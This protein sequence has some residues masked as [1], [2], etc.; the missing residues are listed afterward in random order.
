MA[1]GKLWRLLKCIYGLIDGPRMWYVELKDTLLELGMTLSAF[2]GS[3]FFCI[4]RKSV[5]GLIALHVDDLMFGGSE[6]FLTKVI[7]SLKRKFRLST[8]VEASFVYTGLDVNQTPKGIS[9]SQFGYIHQMSEIII[10]A[11]RAKENDAPIT[12]VERKQ[13]RSVGGQLLWVATQS[14][15]DISYG[16]CVTTNSYSS[17]TVKDLKMANKTVKY[18]KNNPLCVKFPR[19][20][21]SEA[22]LLIFCD[23]SFANLP[24]GS[25]QGGHVVFVA[26]KS[27]WCCPLTWQSRKIKKVCKSTLA[28]ESWALL[29]GLESAE[30]IAIQLKEILQRSLPLMSCT[31]CKSLHD[32]IRTTNT[33]EDKG[34]RIPMACIR[35]KYN[36]KEAEFVWVPTHLQLADCL[37]K[38]GASSALLRDVLVNG[39]LPSPLMSVVF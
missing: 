2:D 21:L 15:P 26:D 30:L 39:R 36:R 10:D 11:E 19:V 9:V 18:M 7:G 8:E 32:A 22:K 4:Q 14:R 12:E 33:V 1:Q 35:Q 25:S 3:F 20:T 37:T 31:D 27:G 17:G 6:W 28:A 13:L 24:D 38:A 5:C 29:E 34:L 16:T 23:A